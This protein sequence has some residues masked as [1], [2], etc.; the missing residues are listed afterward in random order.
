MEPAA[1]DPVSARHHQQHGICIKGSYHLYG[2]ISITYATSM[3]GN[4]GNTN[5]F[6]AS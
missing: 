4:Y 1:K 2:R 3:W 5:T 6:H